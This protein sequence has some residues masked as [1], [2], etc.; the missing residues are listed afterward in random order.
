MIAKDRDEKE[1]REAAEYELRKR[2]IRRLA[3]ALERKDDRRPVWRTLTEQ[4]RQPLQEQIYS[5]DELLPLGG[6][7]LFAGRYKAGKTTFNGQ[8]LKSWADGSPFLGQYMVHAD[9][10]RPNLTFFNYEMSENQIQRWLMKVGITNTDRVN[11]VNLRGMTTPFGIADVRAETAQRLADMGTGMWVVDPASRAMAGA[12]DVTDNADVTTWL[13]WLDEVK[14]EAGVRDLV[15]NI[16]MGHAAATDAAAERAIGAQA[17]SAWADALWFLNFDKQKHRQFWAEGRDVE[18][19]K[20]YVH[21]DEHTM[22]VMLLPN[23]P[24]AV[25]TQDNLI[26]N[27]IMAAIQNNDGISQA[28]IIREIKSLGAKGRTDDFKEAI[29]DLQDEGYVL[30]QSLG[31]GKG[32]THHVVQTRPWIPGT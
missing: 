31:R 32:N 4:L 23:A 3:D 15:L 9:P 1:I 27:F 7:A 25:E 5:I 13:S 28:G 29:M 24:S 10:D 26:R 18:V 16:H 11:I 14:A 20:Q 12:G 8:L 17:W 22:G 30:V 6:N 21:Y 19:E 2:A